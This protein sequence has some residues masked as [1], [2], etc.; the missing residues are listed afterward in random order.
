M[1][2]TI[3]GITQ[4][5]HKLERSFWNSSLGSD[6]QQVKKKRKKEVIA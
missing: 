1:I 5:D 3:A 2:A 6:N 4:L